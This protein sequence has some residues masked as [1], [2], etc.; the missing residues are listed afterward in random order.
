MVQQALAGTAAIV[1]AKD[2]EG[3]YLFANRQ[4]AEMTGR[5]LEELG[6]RDVML[7]AELPSAVA[8]TRWCSPSAGRSISRNTARSTERRITTLVR[9]CAAAPTS[10]G[11]RHDITARSAPSAAPCG[12]RGFAGRRRR[13]GAGA[14]ALPGHD[15]E[16]GH[17]VDRC[18]RRRRRRAHGPHDRPL[19]RRRLSR[20]LHVSAEHHSVPDGARR[21]PLLPQRGPRSLSRFA[22]TR[23]AG[24]R[25]LRRLSATRLGRP[26]SW[27]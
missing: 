10:L 3:R 21:V 5:P 6:R 24:H 27:A 25:R 17:R 11:H 22:R 7:P 26:V 13:P 4:F 19:R 8:T 14:D 20:E 12:A 9:C 1:F 16:R 18:H 23:P 2:S 15:P